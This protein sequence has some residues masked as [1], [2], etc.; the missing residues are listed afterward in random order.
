[1]IVTVQDEVR[2]LSHTQAA[3][4]D[5]RRALAK[6]LTHRPDRPIRRLEI[7]AAKAAIKGVR[8]ANPGGPSH[9]V[10]EKGGTPA[11][12]GLTTLG[13]SDLVRC[14]KHRQCFDHAHRLCKKEV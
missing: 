5:K 6:R 8:E 11:A 12:A 2:N 7:E 9:T 10:L 4:I 14:N 1:V 13:A 3:A